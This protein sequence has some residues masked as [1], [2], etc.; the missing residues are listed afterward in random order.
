MES[1]ISALENKGIIQCKRITG[2]YVYASMSEK[3]SGRVKGPFLS[4][5]IAEDE[6]KGAGWYGSHG[7]TKQAEFLMDPDGILYEYDPK[8]PLKFVDLE[9]DAK[10]EMIEKIKSKLSE[11]EIKFLNIE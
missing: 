11:K 10:K 6:C 8:K 9:R 7:E 4:Y 1:L 2:W 5:S 3:T